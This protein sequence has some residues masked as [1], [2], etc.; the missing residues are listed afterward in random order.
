[1]VGR[2]GS[3]DGRRIRR[4]SG[5]TRN[6]NRINKTRPRDGRGLAR[7]SRNGQRRGRRA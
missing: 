1:M 2:T 7:G 4:S 6:G 3:R 5:C